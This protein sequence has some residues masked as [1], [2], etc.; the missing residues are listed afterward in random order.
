LCNNE[1]DSCFVLFLLSIVTKLC[2]K[3][4]KMQ[5]KGREDLYEK[6]SPNYIFGCKRT[7][8]ASDYYPTY[9]RSNVQLVTNSIERVTANSIITVDGEEQIDVSF[10][11]IFW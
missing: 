10:E 9:L 3:F 2:N 4:R 11:C 6:L 7:C 8:F 5:L 1:E